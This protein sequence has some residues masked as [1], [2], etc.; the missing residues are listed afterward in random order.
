[1]GNEKVTIDSIAKAL[2][3]SKTTVSRAISGKGRVGK[4]TRKRVLNYCRE[5]SY[6]T[7]SILKA[8]EKNRTYN[9][10]AVIPADQ[11]LQ[12]IP[13]FPNCLLGICDWAAKMDYNVVVVFIEK[14]GLTQLEKIIRNQKVDGVILLRALVQDSAADYLIRNKIPLVQIGD[15]KNTSV[16]HVDH[17]SVRACKEMTAFL[18]ERRLQRI[19][20]IGGDKE[21]IVTQRRLAGFYAGFALFHKNPKEKLIYLD[22][23]TDMKVYEAVERIVENYAECIICMDDKICCQV[24]RKLRKMH[25][26]VPRDIEVVSYYDSLTLQNFSPAITSLRFDERELGKIACK[27]L[28]NSLESSDEKSFLVSEY[29]MELRESTKKR[30]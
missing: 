11:S 23:N 3:C 15:T 9:L 2:G 17:D 18:L 28:I 20:L 27:K 14:D 10:A 12:E 29:S 21:H 22:C 7:G 13:F 16:I 6:R 30:I 25:M 19:A 4:E 24:L 1:M 5:H 8:Y 26:L